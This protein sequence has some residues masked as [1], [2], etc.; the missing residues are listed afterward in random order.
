VPTWAGFLYLA[1][2]LDAFGRRIVGWAIA[3]HLTTRLLLDAL[4]MAHAQR[5]PTAVIHH[6]DHGCQPGFNWSSQYRVNVMHSG[7]AQVLQLVFSK[8]ASYGAWC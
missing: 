8:R 4:A 2:V 3:T 6:S 7:T 5:H 1:V